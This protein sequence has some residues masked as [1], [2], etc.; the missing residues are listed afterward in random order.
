MGSSQAKSAD[1]NSASG[2]AAPQQITAPAFC[3]KVLINDNQHCLGMPVRAGFRIP[4]HRLLR[5]PGQRGRND[6]GCARAHTVSTPGSTHARMVG[7]PLFQVVVESEHEGDL[8]EITEPG[9]L[10]LADLQASSRSE[11]YKLNGKSWEM[12]QYEARLA[13]HRIGCPLCFSDV[14]STHDLSRWMITGPGSPGNQ[15]SGH[16]YRM[17]NLTPSHPEGQFVETAVNRVRGSLP[18]ATSV[19]MHGSAAKHGTHVLCQSVHH[20]NRHC[21]AM[22]VRAASGFQRIGC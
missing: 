16:G 7:V 20:D 14:P 18:M 10:S 2:C 9:S 1:G 22:S 21:V 17:S 5:P 3:V 4:A 15:D 6:G 8:T 13:I 19:R 12:T 11:F